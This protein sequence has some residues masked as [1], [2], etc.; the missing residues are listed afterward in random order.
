MHAPTSVPI[1]LEK[2]L[3]DLYARQYDSNL[4]YR[5]VNRGPGTN[6]A[7]WGCVP[8]VRALVRFEMLSIA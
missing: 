4:H 8:L 3:V 7:V 1:L 5:A 2:C 6:G